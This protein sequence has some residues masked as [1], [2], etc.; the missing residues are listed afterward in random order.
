MMAKIIAAVTAAV[1]A[2]FAGEDVVATINTLL[3]A[4]FKTVA[5]EED[6][7]YPVAL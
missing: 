2:V 3:T 7:E 6:F 4:I 5:E 1:K